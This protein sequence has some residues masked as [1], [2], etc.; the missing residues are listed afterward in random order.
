MNRHLSPSCSHWHPHRLLIGLQSYHI[1][2]Q[3]SCSS[4]ASHVLHVGDFL[5]NSDTFFI[6]NVISFCPNLKFFT[7]YKYQQQL[8]S[9]II[10]YWLNTV[11]IPLKPNEE[12]Y[13]GDVV[14]F[15]GNGGDDGA[16]LRNADTCIY[17]CSILHLLLLYMR[18]MVTG[19]AI[20]NVL[21]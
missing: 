21:S 4:H 19:E 2:T 6:S 5:D 3:P 14:G 18:E 1:T 20:F 16:L 15:F 7:R 9:Y 17:Y 10:T 11:T 12:N 8:Y 13:L